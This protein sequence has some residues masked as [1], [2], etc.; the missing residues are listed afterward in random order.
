MSD[1][2]AEPSQHPA[3]G[4][5]AITTDGVKPW[6]A[7]AGMQQGGQRGGSAD[8]NLQFPCTQPCQKMGDRRLARVCE[9]LCAP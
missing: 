4:A 2:I 3:A 8:M 6:L 1:C 5:G 9:H 7:P